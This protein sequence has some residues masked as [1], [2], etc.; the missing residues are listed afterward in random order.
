MFEKLIRMVIC[1]F[2]IFAISCSSDSGTDDTPTNPPVIPPV[3]NPPV[4]PTEKEYKYTFI[5]KMIDENYWFSGGV[6][7]RLEYE[8]EDYFEEQFG[9]LSPREVRIKGDKCYIL[10]RSGIETTYDLTWNNKI[11]TIQNST[12]RIENY[13]VQN[14]D[15]SHIILYL[16]AYTS[17]GI[18]TDVKSVIESK[19]HNYGT[20]T[21]SDFYK[22]TYD[23][24]SKEGR[25]VRVYM[26]Y[27]LNEE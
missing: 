18:G 3:I 20:F 7:K 22:G 26:T 24:D 10:S 8:I 4:T 2:A 19:G 9:E 5:G 17:R 1:V 21:F 14:D 27:D 13:F 23:I 11:G 15:N 12:E 6:I 16:S 25:F